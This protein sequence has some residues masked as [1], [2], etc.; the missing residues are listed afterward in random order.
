MTLI[1]VLLSLTIMLMALAAIGQL[2][3]IGSDRGLDARLTKRGSRLA[4]QKM[5]EIETGVIPLDS[6]SSGGSFDN[7]DDSDWTWTGE[8]QPMGPPNLYQ[9]T[10][11]VKRTIR[12][13]PFEVSLG[14]MLF[15]PA[16]TG[17]A[18]QAEAPPPD[19][20]TSGGTSP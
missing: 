8:M 12:G 17:S 2:V 4:E 9:V 14:R 7:P 5:T 15:D 10:I 16:M 19:T 3:G 11:T 13:T 1:E 20:S 18:A 6:A